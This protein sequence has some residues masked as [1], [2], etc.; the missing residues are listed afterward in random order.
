MLRP[1]ESDG[2][3]FVDS[4]AQAVL[5]REAAPKDVLAWL[6]CHRPHLRAQ[7]DKLAQRFFGRDQRNGWSSWLITHGTKAVLWSDGPIHG[8]EMLSPIVELQSV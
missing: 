2:T 3:S 8:L 7:T 1:H 4:M 6:L 5:V